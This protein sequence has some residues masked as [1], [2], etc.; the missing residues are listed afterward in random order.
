MPP[1]EKLQLH[2]HFHHLDHQGILHLNYLDTELKLG[3]PA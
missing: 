3:N 1:Q 2:L